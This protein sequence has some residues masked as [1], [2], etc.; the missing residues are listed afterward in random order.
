MHWPPRINE[1]VYSQS[2]MDEGLYPDGTI[3][4]VEKEWGDEDQSEVIVEFRRPSTIR[5]AGGRW[6]LV[7]NDNIHWDAR[8]DLVIKSQ[9]YEYLGQEYGFPESTDIC[10]YRFYDLD[11][12]WSSSSGGQAR[13]EVD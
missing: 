6:V 12:N 3:V 2:R 1:R 11:G 9:R 4:H 5:H 7:I 8:D 13:W 10:S